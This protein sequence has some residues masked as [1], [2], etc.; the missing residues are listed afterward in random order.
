MGDRGKEKKRGR[1]GGKEKATVTRAPDRLEALNV[2][3]VSFLLGACER[4]FS[5]FLFIRK[6]TLKR[7]H[8][9]SLKSIGDRYRSSSILCSLDHRSLTFYNVTKYTKKNSQKQRERTKRSLS[10]SLPHKFLLRFPNTW[11]PQIRKQSWCVKGF[12]S[13]A[14]RC[15]LKKNSIN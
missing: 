5:Y 8:K 10:S 4:I 13:E 3:K 2:L 9:R 14:R 1:E 12:F 15:E 7:T 11:H 6:L